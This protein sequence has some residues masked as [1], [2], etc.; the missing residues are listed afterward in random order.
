MK[1]VTVNRSRNL[2][3]IVSTNQQVGTLE[4]VGQFVYPVQLAPRCRPA[5]GRVVHKGGVADS[6]TRLVSICPVP[7]VMPYSDMKNRAESTIGNSEVVTQILNQITLCNL[8]KS[9]FMVPEDHAKYQVLNW[10]QS[11]LKVLLA[12]PEAHC[13]TKGRAEATTDPG[14]K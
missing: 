6:G 13:G 5:T 1:P 11:V 2:H 4:Q 12:L 3:M 10:T 9:C 14:V 7:R 8:D